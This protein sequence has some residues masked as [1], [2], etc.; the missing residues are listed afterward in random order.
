MVNNETKSKLSMATRCIRD[1]C[2]ES[3]VSWRVRTT[4]LRCASDWC[5]EA[6]DEIEIEG[7]ENE[8]CE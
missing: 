8:E 3:G 6:A 4:W 5:S 1:A 2:K 7:M